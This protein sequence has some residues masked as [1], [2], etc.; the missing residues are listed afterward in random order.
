MN[1]LDF[2]KREKE[3]ERDP[4]FYV[5]RM[6]VLLARFSFPPYIYC[7]VCTLYTV[8]LVRTI[9]YNTINISLARFLF[10]PVHVVQCVMFRAKV[11]LCEIENNLTIKHN[12]N[13]NFRFN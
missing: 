1:L 4:V 7:T 12:D 11:L 2:S 9:Q 10:R 13:A 5:R 3:R 8:S 6:I